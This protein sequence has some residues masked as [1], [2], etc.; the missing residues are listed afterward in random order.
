MGIGYDPEQ[1]WNGLL[2]DSIWAMLAAPALILYVFYQFAIT[3]GYLRWMYKHK[4]T[5]P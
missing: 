1:F 5:E 4:K 2:N 3:Q